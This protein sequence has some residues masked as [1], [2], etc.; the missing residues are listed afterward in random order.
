MRSSKFGSKAARMIGFAAQVAATAGVKKK[1]AEV[2]LRALKD[3]LTTTLQ[4]EGKA[5]IP[6]LLNWS[7]AMKPEKTNNRFR[8]NRSPPPET[9]H[10]SRSTGPIE[11][12]S[13]LTVTKTELTCEYLPTTL[14]SCF[15]YNGMSCVPPRG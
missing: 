13:H 2:L 9:Q 8:E 4:A 11:A 6:S 10:E 15:C 5:R 12:C 3:V 7:I 1:H 14:R